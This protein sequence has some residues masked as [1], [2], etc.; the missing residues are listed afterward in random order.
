M[1]WIR[2]YLDCTAAQISDT[3]ETLEV[4]TEKMETDIQQ[5]LEG[6]KKLETLLWTSLRPQYQTKVQD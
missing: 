5:V 2:P 3:L 6:H 1:K 4:E